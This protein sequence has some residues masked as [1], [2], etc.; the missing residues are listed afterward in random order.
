MTTT[1]SIKHEGPHDHDIAVQ[2]IDP[3][4]KEPLTT[5]PQRLSCGYGATFHIWGGQSL[6]IDEIP[7][8]QE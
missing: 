1:V 6:Q 3:E 7:K 8:V 5:T 2:V 4:T